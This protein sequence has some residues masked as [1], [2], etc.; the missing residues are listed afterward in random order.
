M[1]RP[2]YRVVVRRN[3]NAIKE[4]RSVSLSPREAVASL[5]AAD[6]QP[7]GTFLHVYSLNGTIRHYRYLVVYSHPKRIEWSTK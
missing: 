5:Q 1:K 2:N 4:V 3:G 7:D 6:P